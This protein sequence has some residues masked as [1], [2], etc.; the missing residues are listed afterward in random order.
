MDESLLMC[1]GAGN[2]SEAGSVDLGGECNEWGCDGGYVIADGNGGGAEGPG[3]VEGERG[4]GVSVVEDCEG[5]TR[6]SRTDSRQRCSVVADLR[7]V[8]CG[9]EQGR[10]QLRR[11]ARLAQHSAGGR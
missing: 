4:V 5:V 2:D 1:G 8:S 6:V 7:G 10:Q 11:S 9:S 3:D